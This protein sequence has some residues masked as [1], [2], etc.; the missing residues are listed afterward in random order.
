[1]S[2]GRGV[3]AQ[4]VELRCVICAELIPEDRMKRRAVTCKDDCARE[5]VNRKRMLTGR[6]KCLV[7]MRPS[8][9]AERRGFRRFRDVEKKR[10]DL[11]Y[12]E[13]FAQFQKLPADEEFP[14][15]SPEAFRR[16]WELKVGTEE[17]DDVQVNGK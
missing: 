5:F 8:T 6:K 13:K 7:C 4:P 17:G 12:P 10:P 15:R 9:L 3:R 11:I 16:Y 2:Q 1:M 14:D